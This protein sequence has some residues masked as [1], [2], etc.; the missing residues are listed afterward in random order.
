MAGPSGARGEKVNK[1]RE[2]KNYRSKLL[3]VIHRDR[4]SYWIFRE[5]MGG[6]Q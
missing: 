1:Y 6:E 3:G 5:C 2:A 4:Q